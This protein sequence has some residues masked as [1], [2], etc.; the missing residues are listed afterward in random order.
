MAFTASAGGCLRGSRF[1]AAEM[2]RRS[3][4]FATSPSGFA[5]WERPRKWSSPISSAAAS[6]L[7][8]IDAPFLEQF[9]SEWPSPWAVMFNPPAAQ[10]EVKTT[11]ALLSEA[12]V[13]PSLASGAQLDK[14]ELAAIRAVPWTR[15]FRE[16]PITDP[17]GR[18]IEDAVEYVASQPARFVLKRAWEY[19]GKAV[20]V[21]KAAGE[22]SFA[23][24][25]R[26]AYGESLDWPQL[27]RRAAEDRVGGGFVVQEFIPI[28]AHR[29]L[30]CSAQGDR[31]S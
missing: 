14:G 30:V 23:E 11:F 20:F 10:F 28:T 12:M 22:P 5:S 2:I 9:F 19:G 3:P 27:C 18:R 21:G 17:S 13:D 1:S 4:S 7:H 24:R 25:S 6:G 29:I 15:P 31:K 16:G 26:T 8:E